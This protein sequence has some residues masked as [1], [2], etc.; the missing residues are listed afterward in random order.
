V[1]KDDQAMADKIND[2]LKELQ[3]NGTF[4][5]ISEK[6]FGEDVTPN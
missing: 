5:E 2:G 4:A 1:R 3:D 6:W